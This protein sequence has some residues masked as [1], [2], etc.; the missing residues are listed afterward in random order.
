M[1]GRLL[2]PA[3]ARVDERSVRT[4]HVPAFDW[5]LPAG[6]L[7]SACV[8]AMIAAGPGDYPGDAGPGLST[9][10][11]GNVG[12][13]FS[14]QPA[15][16]ALPQL[17]RAPFALLAGA[18]ND[19]AIGIYRWGDLPCLIA[20][21]VLSLWLARIAASR[22]MARSG[23]V[24]IV[25]VCMFNP[26]VNDALYYGHPEELLT[27]SLA[28]AAL[29]AASERRATTAAMLAGLAVAS[30]QWALLAVCPVLLAAEGRRLRSAA[31]MAGTAALVSA[32]MVLGDFSAFMH[33]LHY[34]SRP[35]PVT[36]VFTWLYPLS[37]AGHVTIA[38]IFG[39]PRPGIGHTVPG[40]VSLL[41]HP[42][43]IALGV[44]VPLI[45]WLLGGRRLDGRPLLLSAA[46]VFLFRSTLD[47]GTEP[48]YYLPLL[49]VLVALDAQAGDRFPVA[50]LIGFAGAFTLLDRFADYSAPATTN[51]LYIA[52]T[53]AGAAVLID[54]LRSA[55]QRGLDRLTSDGERLG[56]LAGVATAGPS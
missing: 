14:H 31:V 30:K 6:A 52:G 10:A 16:G 26:L 23:Q 53:L 36:T 1:Q 38:N 50:G 8:R 22:G 44:V 4:R 43:I 47:P 13:F 25:C 51:L 17:V 39:A 35:Q 54:R 24:L 41:S 27:A 55:S 32:P 34:I 40:V 42:A 21:A 3:H 19:S 18:L 15:M 5:L 29:L 46:V 49:F 56:K 9:L 33:S 45:A 28:A 2:K 37:P 7:L 11:H 48:Y 12:G 20:V